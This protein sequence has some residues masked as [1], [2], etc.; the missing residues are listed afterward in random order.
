MVQ[1][2]D[3]RDPRGLEYV[4]HK[5]HSIALALGYK[6]ENETRTGLR[7]LMNQ[8]GLQ[9]TLRELGVEDIDLIAREGLSSERAL[10]QPRLVTNPQV[11]SILK[12]IYE[13]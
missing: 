11:R 9:T 7:A 12:G 2:S 5:N 3:C 13:G 10:N 4:R 8:V 1:E 6:D